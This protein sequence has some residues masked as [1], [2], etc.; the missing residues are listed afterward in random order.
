MSFH[1]SDLEKQLAAV[2]KKVADTLPGGNW[3]LLE[4][5]PYL[6]PERAD[7]VIVGG[8]VV[9]W[10]IAYWLKK[11]ERVHGALQVVVVEKDLTVRIPVTP[12]FNCSF[13]SSI[14]SL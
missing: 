3:T 11:K 12:V 8:G 4:V 5:N 7:I 9:G 6:P 2:R 1:L 14:I 10:S 13:P